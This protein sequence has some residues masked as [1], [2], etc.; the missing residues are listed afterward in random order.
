MHICSALRLAPSFRR[1]ARPEV[2]P[3]GHWS[4]VTLPFGL[5]LGAQTVAVALILVSSSRYLC[6]FCPSNRNLGRSLPVRLR[7]TFLALGGRVTVSWDKHRHGLLSQPVPPAPSTGRR[8]RADSCPRAGSLPA[9]RLER[10]RHLRTPSRSDGPLGCQ[11]PPFHSYTTA[12]GFDS[13]PA[14]RR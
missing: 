4:R 13:S 9:A 10:A 12:A 6:S 3:S 5:E 2:M 7:K 1:P 8:S 11:T 14:R